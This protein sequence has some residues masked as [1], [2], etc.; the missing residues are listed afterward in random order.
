MWL[1]LAL[2]DDDI[3]IELPSTDSENGIDNIPLV[4]GKGKSHYHHR[5]RITIAKW[6]MELGSLSSNGRWN[7]NHYHQQIRDKTGNHHRHELGD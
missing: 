3:I 7:W 2:D 4:I 1:E 5:T 6:E